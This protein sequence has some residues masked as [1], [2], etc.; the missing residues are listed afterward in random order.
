MAETKATGIWLLYSLRKP[1]LKRECTYITLYRKWT[2]STARSTDGNRF[3]NK[4]TAF[5]FGSIESQDDYVALDC[6]TPR[7]ESKVKAINFY[8]KSNVF[9]TISTD[10]AE[11]VEPVRFKDSYFAFYLRKN[12]LRK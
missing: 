3:K 12:R 9:N 4:S 2:C 8:Y 11:S 6:K 1:T 5:D 10:G 7:P